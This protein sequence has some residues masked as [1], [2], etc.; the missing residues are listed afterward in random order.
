MSS[1]LL[2][3]SVTGLNAAQAGL[4]TTSHNIANASTPGFNRQ[5]I[6][7]SSNTPQFEGIG[8]IGRGTNVANVQRVYDNF[9]ATQVLGAQTT[10]SVLPH[11]YRL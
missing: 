10:A 9:L 11:W 7:Q 2:N 8:F 4:L 6:I 5:Q 1:G 3:I